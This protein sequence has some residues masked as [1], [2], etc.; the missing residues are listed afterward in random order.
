MISKRERKNS[1]PFKAKLVLELGD[2]VA[3][4]AVALF[5]LCPSIVG[6]VLWRYPSNCLVATHSHGPAFQPRI[7][8]IVTV[9]ELC[10]GQVWLSPRIHDVHLRSSLV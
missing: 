3:L 2:N 8:S 7:Q 10:D 4:F 1:S 5:V 9:F 6:F